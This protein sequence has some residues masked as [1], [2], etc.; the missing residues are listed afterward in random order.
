MSSYPRVT[1]EFRH[2]LFCFC[3]L[4]DHEAIHSSSFKCWL[5]C[6]EVRNNTY[7]DDQQDVL[8]VIS[9]AQGVGTEESKVALQELRKETLSLIKTDL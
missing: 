2:T 5:F 4:D 1:F 7:H 8:K 3:F 6:Y 9:E